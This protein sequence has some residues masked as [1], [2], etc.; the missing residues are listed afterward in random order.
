[1]SYVFDTNVVIAAFNGESAVI[2]KL[3]GLEPGDVILCAPV[4]A[5]LEFGAHLSS[6][7]EEN[8][9][10]IGNLIASTRYEPFDLH[11]ARLFGEV[12]A[13]LKRRGVVKTDF[14]LAIA[15]MALVTGAVLV[16]EDR[17]FFDGSIPGLEVENWLRGKES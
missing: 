13:D 7:K 15:M 1:M 16:S 17:T 12:K 10:R 8:L 4:L 14:D 11:A 9:A 2:E 5:E 6:R 3:A